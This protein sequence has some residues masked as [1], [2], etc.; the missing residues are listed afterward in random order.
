[1]IIIAFC[2]DVAQASI[3]RSVVG[4]NGDAS[5]AKENTLKIPEARKF[6]RSETR[7]SDNAVNASYQS[8]MFQ[9]Y[10]AYIIQQRR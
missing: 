1:M 9:V 2:G 4:G 10:A 5:R 7:A 8:I 6:Q 3:V